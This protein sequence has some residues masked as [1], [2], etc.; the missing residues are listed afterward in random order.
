MSYDR[1]SAPHRKRVFTALE[2][3]QPDRAP[4]FYRDIP[5]VEERLLN[6]LQL[7]NREQLFEF[8]EIDFR[9]VAPEY[10]GPPLKDYEKETVK[11][12]WGVE[13][14]YTRFDEKSG[15]WEPDG[16][17]LEKCEEPGDLEYY[18]WPKVEWFDFFRI[19][20]DF[21]GQNGLLFSPYTWRK[22]LKPALHRLSKI[23]HSYDAYYYHHSC[24][25]VRELIP[26][27]I[28]IGIDVL[29]PVQVRAA[30]MNPS[31][32][33]Y[34]YGEKISFSGGIDEQVLLREGSPADVRRGVREL[35]DA[36]G[37]DGGFFIG[38]THNFQVDIPTGNIVAMYEE[39]R[40]YKI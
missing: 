17:P 23:A 40:T 7:S 6:D 35:I 16:N 1:F 26:D 11:D 10:I 27:F 31:E 12:I 39:A 30:G 4:L 28:E 14:K 37:R 29:D 3:R 8:F 15:Y 2:H 21:G 13:Y 9:W 5:E 24:G 33:K 25:S 19:G 22:M 36:M 20:D 18:T 32:L 38:P 34:E